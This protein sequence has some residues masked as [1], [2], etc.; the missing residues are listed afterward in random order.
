[1]LYEELKLEGREYML[2][3]LFEALYTILSVIPVERFTST[4]TSTH[5]STHTPTHLDS[6]LDRY[7]DTYV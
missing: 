7:V 2:R 5:T 1:M 4:R 6:H 3:S